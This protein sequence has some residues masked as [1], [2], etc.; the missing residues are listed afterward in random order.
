MIFDCPALALQIEGFVMKPSCS[1]MKAEVLVG[2]QSQGVHVR[3]D[4]TSV[5]DFGY[6][7]PDRNDAG[8]LQQ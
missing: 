8:Q 1:P 7:I 3:P 6:M 4:S 5:Y 2:R